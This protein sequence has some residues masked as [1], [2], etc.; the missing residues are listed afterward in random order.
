M[1]SRF[2]TGPALAVLVLGLAMVG[3]VSA[4]TVDIRL[5]Q[6]GATGRLRF[7]PDYLRLETG[8]RL[9]F[10]VGAGDALV[11]SIAGMLPAG[12]AVQRQKPGQSLIVV[13]DKDGVYGFACLPHYQD[14]V[15]ALF[16]ASKPANELAAK[17]VH[18]P[19]A[20]AQRIADFFARLD[21]G[22]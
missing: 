12:V 4:R 14:G 15:V 5:H 17:A 3:P 13:L 11:G 16:L 22:D 19:P 6:D 20:A 1:W 8:D 18:H 9:R 21:D 10:A 7:E 2:I